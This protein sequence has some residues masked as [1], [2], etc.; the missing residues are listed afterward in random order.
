MYLVT[1]I[2]AHPDAKRPCS[3]THQYFFE[4]EEDARLF[5]QTLERKFVIDTIQKMGLDQ[6]VGKDFS[7][8]YFYGEV[9]QMEQNPIKTF[10][11]Q[12]PQQLKTFS[13]LNVHKKSFV[14]LLD[15]GNGFRQPLYPKSFDQNDRLQNYANQYVEFIISKQNKQKENLNIL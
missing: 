4:T 8:V 1:A 5:Q 13:Q 12:I 2:I 14:E 7:E 11:S 9:Y 10:V 6:F 3:T 15:C